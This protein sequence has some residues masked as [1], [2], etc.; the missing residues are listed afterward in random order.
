MKGTER[1]ARLHAQLGPSFQPGEPGLPAPSRP[2]RARSPPPA[3][4][5]Q[6]TRPRPPD[7]RCSARGCA[8]TRRRREEAKATKDLKRGQAIA[9][10]GLKRPL[11]RPLM[12][13]SSRVYT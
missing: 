7:K 9:H 6:A 10:A 12:R 13:R 8:V 2:S 3:P 5:S 4:R 1:E 11:T